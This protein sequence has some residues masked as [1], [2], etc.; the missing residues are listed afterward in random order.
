MAQEDFTPELPPHLV[1]CEELMAAWFETMLAATDQCFK[2][3]MSPFAPPLEDE[4]EQAGDLDIPGPLERDL[5]H[6]LFA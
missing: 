3:W 5:E 2:F 6:N 4:V 1:L